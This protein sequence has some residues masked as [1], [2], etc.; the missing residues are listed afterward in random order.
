MGQQHQV[1]LL[2]LV[3]GGL[4]V[5]HKS[6]QRRAAPVAACTCIDENEFGAS[7][8]EVALDSCRDLLGIVLEGT[9]QEGLDERRI[10]MQEVGVNAA[11][12]VMKRGD[13]IVANHCAIEAR[14]LFVLHRRCRLGRCNSN[15]GAG[16]C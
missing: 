2:R 9:R 11:A 1:N 5:L 6:A 16:K 10:A 13:F 4:Q 3:A 14:N 12:A 7:V 15:E 8:D